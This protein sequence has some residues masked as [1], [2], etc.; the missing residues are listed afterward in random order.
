MKTYK[1]KMLKSKLYWYLQ[2][3]ELH[4]NNQKKNEEMR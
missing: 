4:F 3:S 2:I 1:V